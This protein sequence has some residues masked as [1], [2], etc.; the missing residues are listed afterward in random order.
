MPIYYPVSVQE[1]VD[2]MQTDIRAELGTVDF[3]PASWFQALVISVG[4]RHYEEYEQIKAGQLMS[5]PNTAIG[6]YQDDWFS[7]KGI[8]RQTATQA[9]GE[10]NATGT[11]GSVIPA[12]TRLVSSTGK[13][14]ITRT[15]K[16]ITQQV[17]SPSSLTRSGSTATLT[18][19][20]EHNIATGIQ[21]VIAG[22]DQTEYNGTFSLVAKSDTELTY[23]ITG[24]PATPATGTI[25][26]TVEIASIPILSIDYGSAVN[27]SSGA[28]LSLQGTL[29]GVNTIM[30]VDFGGIKGGSDAEGDVSYNERGMFAYTN[31]IAQFNN[32]QIVQTVLLVPEVTRT[33]VF[34]ATPDRGNVTIYFVLDLRDSIYPTAD[35]INRVRSEIE[36]IRPV[37][38]AVSDVIIAAP[39]AVVVDFTFTSLVPNTPS[40]Q[41]AIAEN[42]KAFF[43]NNSNVGVSIQQLAYQAAIHDTI[44]PATGQQVQSFALSAPAGD[45]IV[46]SGSL[47]ALGAINWNL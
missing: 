20:N 25:T 38:L 33:W 2:R 32:S 45:I 21:G 4:G 41:N 5:F 13:E 42:L 3:L 16:V 23:E 11:L 10:V 14:Y 19:S 17:L 40:M 44:D 37:N 28:Q 36:K 27:L 24:T 43:F 46:A 9:N 12:N 47:A 18:F 7:L 39:T 22:A 15:D 1:V 26:L 8:N 30:L 34:D 29:S 31:P 6:Q 35:D